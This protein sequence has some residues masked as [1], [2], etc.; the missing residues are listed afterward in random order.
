M[1][2]A[3]RKTNCPMGIIKIFL[4]PQ[5]HVLSDVCV[6]VCV[7]HDSD[8]P[9]HEQLTWAECQSHMEAMKE[10]INNSDV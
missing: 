9:L 6:C 8:G 1:V 10:L 4:I 2:S 7:T 5:L 3:G